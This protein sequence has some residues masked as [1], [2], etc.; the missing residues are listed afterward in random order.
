MCCTIGG[1]GGL[2]S[3][4]PDGAIL[5]AQAGAN[6]GQQLGADISHVSQG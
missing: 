4:G 1:A 3:S 6:R 5:G 2:L